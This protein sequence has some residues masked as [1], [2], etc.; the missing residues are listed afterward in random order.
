MLFIARTD[1]STITKKGNIDALGFALV[2]HGL[3]TRV[4]S[5]FFMMNV[6]RKI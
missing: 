4:L 6:Q 3:P 5:K 2:M 1:K